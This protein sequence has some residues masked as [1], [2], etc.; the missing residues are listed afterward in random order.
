[1]DDVEQQYR[2]IVERVRRYPMPEAA[3][4]AILAE[5]EEAYRRELA[6]LRR[7]GGRRRNRGEV[8]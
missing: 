3:R 8:G 7:A 6:E 2:A 1:M 4:A 5:I